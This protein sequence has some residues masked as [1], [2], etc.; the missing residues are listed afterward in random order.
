[1][2]DLLAARAQMGVSLAFHIVFALVGMGM[3][4]LMVVAERRWIVTGD[5]IYRELAQRWAKGT[6]ILFAVGAVSGTVLSFELGLLWPGFMRFA[7]AIIGMP[8]S[9][10]GFAFFMEA[11]FL[12]IYMYGWDHV[13]PRAHLA[14]GIVVAASGMA[15]G[16]FV[17]I[18]N[19]WMNTPTGFELAG[20]VPV[21]IH[22]LEA[23]AN[24]AAPTQTLHMVL[25]AYAATGFA[26]AGIHAFL[27]LRGQTNAFHRRAL[28]IALWVGCPAAVLQP[29]SGDLAARQVA[30]YQPVK[31]AAMEAVFHT[32]SGAPLVLGG[33]PDLET[34]TTKGAL[35]IPHGLSLLAFHD[36]N[37][38][39]K[40]LD[41]V[42]RADW[43]NVPAVH[44]SFQLMV[45][46]GTYMALVA[47]WVA[48]RALRTGALAD[49]RWLLRAVALAT[50]MGFV[51]TE[52]GWMTTE[53]GRQPW[54]IY[55][56]L[57]TRD[58]VTP[59]P[60]LVVPFIM[61]TTLYCFLGVIV[62]L[63]LYRQILHSPQVD[64]GVWAH[65]AP[66]ARHADA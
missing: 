38:V 29:L 42:P 61:F 31:L 62:A 34:E 2:Q 24:P 50:P 7:G 18:A 58:A 36:P 63:L 59:M 1:M 30:R 25:A 4:V 44:W 39:V 52:V 10:E 23:L 28:T 26:V 20:G 51:A 19:A 60:G 45:A 35:R 14:A 8:F 9:L 37:A 54:V 11:I 27:L 47:L 41:V 56:V 13:P 32:E 43:P 53:L 12:G 22:P 55:G 15:S 16:V 46:L 66:G 17:V 5:E 65:M 33:W 49:H 40:G 57:R 48:W 3:P 64:E 21:R 6:A